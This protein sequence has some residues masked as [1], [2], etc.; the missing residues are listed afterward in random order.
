MSGQVYMDGGFGNKATA[1]HGSPQL[2]ARMAR[3]DAEDE[4]QAAVEERE[5]EQRAAD[6]HGRAIQASI[7]AALERGE[8]VDMRRAMQHGVART[9][10]QVIAEASARM[11]YEDAVAAARERAEFNAWRLARSGELSADMSAPTQLEVEEGARAA[12]HA[13]ALRASA[14][15]KRLEQGKADRRTVQLAR[16][17]RR[18]GL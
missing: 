17:V 15:S 4:R 18:L 10:Q 8:D 6:L 5:R 12:E 3:I 13:S 2:R 1:E 11:D 14:R 7:A 16:S 9:H